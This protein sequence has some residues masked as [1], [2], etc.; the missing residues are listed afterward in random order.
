MQLVQPNFKGRGLYL[1]DDLSF[2][3]GQAHSISYEETD[4][5]QITK[6]FIENKEQLLYN[7]LNE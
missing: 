7:L 4:N 5:Y 3:D 1:L 6:M 2:D